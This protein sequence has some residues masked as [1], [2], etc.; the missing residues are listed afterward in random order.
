MKIFLLAGSE[1]RGDRLMLLQKELI[2][3]KM[4]VPEIGNT[5]GQNNMK[6]AYEIILNSGSNKIQ[7]QT[8]LNNYFIKVFGAI[9]L[10][11]QIQT[12]SE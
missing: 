7:L 4:C 2:E 12:L 3:R 8:D 11:N 10:E 1:F 6:G 9:L 5:Q